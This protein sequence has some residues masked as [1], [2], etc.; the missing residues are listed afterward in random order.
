[1]TW[2]WQIPVK[3]NQKLILLALSDHAD[4]NGK[5]W[6]GI[7]GLAEKCGLSR[8]AVIEH[9]QFLTELNLISTQKQHDENGYRR[10]SLYVLN[11]SLSPESL[12]RDFLS[13]ENLRRESLSRKNHVLSP[14]LPMS[15][16][17][18]L[19]GNNINRH[20]ANVIE[21]KICPKVQK[22]D[23]SDVSL[24]TVP[25]VQFWTIYPKQGRQKKKRS[26]AIWARNKLDSKLEII[27]ADVKQRS[28]EHAQWING[29]IPHASTY[30]NGEYWRDEIV[31]VSETI[32]TTEP[33]TLSEKNDLAL[34]EFI[35]GGNHAE[36]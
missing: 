25:F 29:F 33:K 1:M 3:S 16:V 12:S 32:K 30:L 6:P 24:D 31:K 11:L 23:I 17:Q 5:C 7:E 8:S 22:A 20:K 10:P 21:S 9:I 18:I 34:Q 36:Q 15:Q 19:D 26:M 14:D 35:A 27:L 13:R 4:D 2:A 28:V